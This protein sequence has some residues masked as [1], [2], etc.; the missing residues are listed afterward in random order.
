MVATQ[1]DLND[2]LGI[3][4]KTGIFKF[5]TSDL[6]HKAFKENMD[7]SECLTLYNYIKSLVIYLEGD[8]KELEDGN[9]IWC[10]DENF[11]NGIGTIDSL[12]YEFI[13]NYY[14]ISLEDIKYKEKEIRIFVDYLFL[15]TISSDSYEKRNFLDKYPVI[16]EISFSNKAL[17]SLIISFDEAYENG[18]T[19]ERFLKLG[20]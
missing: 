15:D 17:S 5:T 11:L 4:Y 16:S 6:M 19:R 3:D 13:T 2:A 1:A 14:D 10:F 9:H 8:Y 20:E 7:L 18:Y 12:F